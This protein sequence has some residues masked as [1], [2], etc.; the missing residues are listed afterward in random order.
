MTEN[1]ICLTDVFLTWYKI[2]V[3][4]QMLKYCNIHFVLSVPLMDR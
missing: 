3:V 4:G 2:H 1:L